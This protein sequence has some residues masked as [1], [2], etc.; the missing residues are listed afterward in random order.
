MSI[1]IYMKSV[2][3]NILDKCGIIEYLIDRYSK[4]NFVVLMY[5]RVLPAK[6]RNPGLEAGM[7]V[8]PETFDLHLRYLKKHFSIRPLSDAVRYLENAFPA[9][10]QP[11]CFLTFNDGWC[12]FYTYAYPILSGHGAPATVFLPTKFI[13]TMDRFWTDSLSRLCLGRAPGAACRNQTGPSH[14]IIELLENGVGSMEGRLERSI[15]SMKALPE[16]EIRPI[17]DGLRERW[18]VDPT[19]ESRDFLIWDEVREM[20]RTGLVSFGSHTETHR[21]LTTLS[22]EEIDRELRRSKERLTEEG[23]ADPSFFPF[24]YPNGNH[25]GE[26]IRFVKDHRYILAVSTMAGWN[27]KDASPFALK[28][29]SVH[30]DMTASMEMFGCRIAE[31]L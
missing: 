27:G 17:L 23:V 31:I 11:M 7:Y 30:Q 22:D 3:A 24:A 13:G 10:R 5:H 6:E 9:K 14:P 20:H 8:E 4:N 26:I 2:A 25:T 28:R 1:S 16:E 21:I 12:D 15:E 29:I 19:P 18:G